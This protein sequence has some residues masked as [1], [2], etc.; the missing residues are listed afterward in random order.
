MEEEEHP[1]KEVDV[2]TIRGYPKTIIFY[3]TMFLSLILAIPAWFAQ[4]IPDPAILAILSFVWIIVFAFNL[5]VVSF[6]FGK[7]IVVALILLVVIAILCAALYVALTG[8]MIPLIN[9]ISLGLQMN[10][11]TFLAFFIIFGIV[12]F[13]SWLS[14]RFYYF[15]ITP[16]E[17]IYKKGILGDVERYATT[18]ITVHKEIRDLFEYILFFFSGRLT[19][20]VPGR[21]TA[22]IIDNIPQINKVENLILQVLRRLEIDID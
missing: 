10:A 20:M 14:T 13:I 12:I 15:R 21:K 4:L 1:P 18:N 6:E 19:I 11:Q 2:V 5:F 17:L 16:N 3:P 9:P 7:G 22:I 8:T